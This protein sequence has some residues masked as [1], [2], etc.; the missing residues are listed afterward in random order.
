MSHYR[1]L[2]RILQKELSYQD[3][4]LRLLST[5]R[6][7]IVK[8]DQERILDIGNQKKKLIGEA[9]ALERE[10]ASVLEKIDLPSANGAETEAKKPFLEVLATCDE[11]AISAELQ[12]T[13]EELKLSAESV[14]TLNE[15]NGD[16]IKQSL[17]IIASTISIMRSSP[18]SDLPTY[19]RRGKLS[20]EE[21]DPAFASRTRG[22]TRSA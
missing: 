6:A 16:L 21:T 5:E 22:Y 8:L 1:K 11:K 18:A 7:A 13:G 17:G 12:K 15:Q 9:V 4:I 14:K 19:G 10:R 3:K 20:S 2:L